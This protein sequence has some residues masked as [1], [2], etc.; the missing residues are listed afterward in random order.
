MLFNDFESLSDG[1]LRAGPHQPLKR[2]N[3][4]YRLFD[5]LG[6]QIPDLNNFVFRQIADIFY[7]VSYALKA[8]SFAFENL[9]QILSAYVF[10]ETKL[11]EFLRVVEK[12]HEGSY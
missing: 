7:F 5:V 6:R 8:R 2:R 12:L 3:P 10:R 11:W 4:A 9:F 1:V